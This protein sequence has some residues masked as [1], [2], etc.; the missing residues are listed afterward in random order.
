MSTAGY[1]KL[2]VP[3]RQSRGNSYWGLGITQIVR[4]R[5]GSDDVRNDWDSQPMRSMGRAAP[6]RVVLSHMLEA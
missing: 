4:C 1:V 5:P 2:F 6:G 3:P